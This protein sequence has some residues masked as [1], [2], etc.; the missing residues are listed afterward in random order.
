MESDDDNDEKH[1]YLFILRNIYH[2]M[3][4]YKSRFGEV[5]GWVF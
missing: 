5:V 3:L 1:F 2:E 4:F